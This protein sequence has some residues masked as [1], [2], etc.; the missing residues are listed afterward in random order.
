MN[1]STTNNR[2][3]SIP[4]LMYHSISEVSERNK[5]IRSVNPAY[6]LAVSQFREQMEY[7]LTNRYT[8]LSLDQL[9]NDESVPQKS[10]VITFDDGWANNYTCVFPILKNYGFTATIFVISG[11][12]GKANYMDWQQVREMSEAGLSIQSHSVSHKPLAQLSKTEVK[13]ELETSKKTIAD[14]LG[15]EVDFL[16]LPHGV[17]NNKVLKIAQEAGYHA[18]CTS[19]P[20]YSHACRNLPVMKRINISDQF[21]IDTFKKILE[22]NEAIIFPMLLSKK[23]KNM[24]K[25][26]IGQEK[27]RKLY[28]L[29][30]RVKS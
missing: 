21:Q 29:R 13:Y 7:L 15:K 25:R 2:I 26:L 28:Q 3:P 22:R 17:F 12:I 1:S 8:T 20:G 10:L 9:L 6:S 19:E 11:S 24:A 14:A 5:K 27:Y 16:S 30:Y 18:I 4:I 23:V